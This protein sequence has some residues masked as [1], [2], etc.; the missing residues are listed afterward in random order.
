[1]GSRSV[2]AAFLYTDIVG[3][4]ELWE[5]HPREMAHGLEQHDRILRQEIESRSGRIFSTAGDSFAAAFSSAV[6][7][8]ESAVAAQVRL[9]E[10]SVAGQSLS[11]RSGVHVGEAQVRDDDYFGTA[12]NRT[13]RLMALAHGGQI[14]VSD[15]AARLSGSADSGIQLQ[16]LGE[17]ELKGLSEA[18]RV[19]Q[20]VDDRLGHDFPS[21]AAPSSRRS[22]LPSHLPKLHGREGDCRS[23]KKLID[24]ERLVT[25]VGPAGAG[26][27]RLAVQVAVE[28]VGETEVEAWI[29]DL[30]PVDDPERVAEAVARVLPT[31]HH[32]TRPP[33]VLAADYLRR[34]SA[35]VVID[36]CEH[37]LAAVSELISYLL[38]E[39]PELTLLTTS[40]ERV[41]I[42]QE[43]AY[44]LEP[45]PTP[46]AGGLFEDVATSPSIQLFVNRARR[47]DPSFSLTPDNY[48]AVSNICRMLDGLPLALEL[49]ASRISL[50]AADQLEELLGER[51]DLLETR[52]RDSQP[53]HRTL[54]AAVDWS[55]DLLEESDRLLFA[56]LSVFPHTFSLTD[57]LDICAYGS[58]DELDVLEGLSRLVEKSLLRKVSHGRLVMLET[59]RRYATEKLDVSGESA[60]LARRHAEHF[61]AILDGI[62]RELDHDEAGALARYDQEQENLIAALIWSI[63][64][65]DTSIGF[66]IYGSLRP[67]WWSRGQPSQAMEWG[68]NLF[69]TE[70][71]PTFDKAR[72]LHTAGAMA[73][74]RN[75]PDLGLQ[76]LSA[77]EEVLRS[78]DHPL[79]TKELGRVL[80]SSSAN[81]AAD[82]STIESASRD[83]LEL[84]EI[85][86]DKVGQ[87]IA[88]MN[89]S[90]VAGW[91][92]EHARSVSLA[93][94]ALTKARAG[95]QQSRIAEAL[96]SLGNAEADAGQLDS[97]RLHLTEALTAARQ[98]DHIPA[99][100]GASHGILR[101][102]LI[103]ED[104]NRAKRAASIAVEH[105]ESALPDLMIHMLVDVARLLIRLEQPEAAG[106]AIAR[107]EET[108]ESSG[109][110]EPLDELA[111]SIDQVR[112]DLETAGVDTG[113]RSTRFEVLKFRLI[114]GLERGDGS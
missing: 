6:A 61:A 76:Y 84:A 4:T 20:I 100:L 67:L 98:A 62:S 45:L 109:V 17:H 12:V 37:L 57:A 15:A 32:D 110:R 43:Q 68:R 3:S 27:T 103:D 35:L 112:S 88:L 70:A 41:N 74:V 34:R 59:I 107:M 94:E 77:A 47:A 79:A 46:A 36:N 55:H 5:A 73:Y 50:L 1:M 24:Q 66:R 33:A 101:I 106:L 26:K 69:S 14:L 113:D 90:V 104:L 25:I 13:A 53:H 42:A 48:A 86:D 64:T 40:R 99:L 63:S 96:E 29:V 8:I 82:L 89:L 75:L 23:L 72:A 38:A 83:A 111:A 52:Q 44:P 78:S 11:V 105:L 30:T 28:W 92:G 85:A 2:I 19:H 80:I 71:D 97:A 114:E 91:R 49:A 102:A 65:G 10:V 60:D 93:E 51:L 31:P 7:A 95:G 22:N 54:L 58:V 56:R 18:E 81:P 87:S 108:I 21:L 16:E 9:K 39:C